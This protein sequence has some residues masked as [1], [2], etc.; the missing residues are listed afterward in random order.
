LVEEKV[1]T[2]LFRGLVFRLSIRD[3]SWNVLLRPLL[4]SDVAELSTQITGLAR[5]GLAGIAD[6]DLTALV[7][8]QVSASAGAVAVGGDRL[9][10]DVVHEGTTSSWESRE[11]DAELDAST[12]GSRDSDNGATDR[13]AFLD[14]QSSNIAGTG[15]AIGDDRGRDNS[16]RLS[17]DSRRCGDE[18]ED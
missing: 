11:G 6:G 10:V 17:A 7:R 8:I 13:A 4:G 14:R 16:R 9:L 18:G 15:G 2:Y 12:F 5:L 1:S 3:K